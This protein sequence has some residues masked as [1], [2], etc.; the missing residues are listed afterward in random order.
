MTLVVNPI[1]TPIAVLPY[2][3]LCDDTKPRDLEKVF[4]ITVTDVLTLNTFDETVSYLKSMANAETGDRAALFEYRIDNNPW[5]SNKPNT[6]TYT[7]S[8]V[9]FGEH[10]IQARDINGCG[11]ESDMVLVMDYPLFFTPNND[12]Y[13]DT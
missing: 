12:G 4:E 5:V 7:F 2:L 13:K 11:I 9:P 3:E 10:V 1:P 8:N 6:N